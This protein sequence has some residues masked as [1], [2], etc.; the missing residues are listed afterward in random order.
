VGDVFGDYRAV[1]EIGVGGMSRVFLGERI[2]GALGRPA[3]IKALLPAYGERGESLRRFRTEGQILSALSHPNIAR[4]LDAGVTPDAKPF[5]IMELVEGLPLDDY[6]RRHNLSLEGRLELFLHVC[7]A[8]EHAHQRLVV[9]RDLKPSNILV[10]AEGQVKLLDFGIAKLLDPLASGIAATVAPTRAGFLLMTPD[11]AAPEQIRGE[12]VTTA[13]DVYALGMVLYE[14]ITGERPYDLRGKPPR[15]I[16][17]VICEM[18]PARP[19]TT[20]STRDVPQAELMR[21]RKRLRGDLDTIV[22]KSLRKEPDRRYGS[23]RELADDL[24]RQIQGLPVQARPATFRYRAGTFLRRNWLGAAA[25]AVLCLALLAVAVT[26]TAQQAATGAQRERAE[27][28]AAKAR[29]VIDFLLQLFEANDPASSRGEEVTARELL[30][31]GLERVDFSSR[32]PLV[33]AEMVEVLGRVYRSLGSYKI[34][35]QQL[36][37]ALELQLEALPPHDLRLAA[38]R[39]QLAGVLTASGSYEEAGALYKEA[40][41]SLEVGAGIADLRTLEVRNSI[42]ALTRA[43]GDNVE[44][45]HQLEKVLADKEAALGPEH[46]SVG[47]SLSDLADLLVEQGEAAK[48]ERLFRRAIGILDA[49]L[50]AEHP[51]SLIIKQRLA[52]ALLEWG[53]FDGAERLGNEIVALQRKSLGPEHPEVAR[54]LNSTL[55]PIKFFRQD[56]AGAEAIYREIIAIQSAAFGEDHP[57]V[58]IALG[59]LSMMIFEQGRLNEGEAMARQVL[60]LK[61]RIHEP[62]HLSL[63]SSLHTL[64]SMLQRRAKY[65]EAETL[66]REALDIRLEQLG[67]RA[68]RVA[69]VQHELGVV[70]VEQGRYADAEPLYRDALAIRRETLAPDHPHIWADLESLAILYERWGKRQQA[71]EMRQE[72]SLLFPEKVAK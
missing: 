57:D 56:Y 49:T 20:G 36:R 32:D 60:E 41:A 27:L 1:Q 9:H 45:Q 26:M 50:G 67:P 63:A 2:D 43:R 7:A 52:R 5:L 23:A 33:K 25:A 46:E 47:T 11:Y 35:E 10:T 72:I 3:A 42:A 34:A 58:A 29:E 30:E 28:E 44:A 12:A 66:L 31:R 68:P 70:L 16:E 40:L 51:R 53:D 62:D 37:R 69:S 6:C 14:L 39:A 8:V 21:R 48:A 59:N 38:S 71:A 61:R 64:G 65:G 55:A 24:R 19:S 13:T 54:T 22:L 15:E 18:E 17:R 4:V